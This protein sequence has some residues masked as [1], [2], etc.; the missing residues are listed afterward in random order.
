MKYIFLLILSSYSFAQETYKEKINGTEYSIDLVLIKGG[1][2]KMGSSRIE[3]GHLGD[4]G[5]VHSVRL[6][7]FW[8][9]KYEITWDLYNLFVSRE[10]DDNQV[11]KLKSSEVQIDVDAVSGA[12]TPYVE[13]SFGMGTDGYPAIC[14]TQ[15]AAVKLQ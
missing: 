3:P 5:P 2:F 11:I 12:T 7:S 8:M 15:L 10:I 1:E 9:G 14:M 4:E 6:D 13:M